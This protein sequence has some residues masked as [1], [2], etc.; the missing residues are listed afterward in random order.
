MGNGASANNA[1][2]DPE[3]A[4]ETTTSSKHHRQSSGDD[5]RR[6][7]LSV[8]GSIASTGLDAAELAKSDVERILKV[9]PVLQK[10]AVADN[11]EAMN[12]QDPTGN[13]RMPTTST[14]KYISTL[15]VKLMDGD[16]D[17]RVSQ[18]DLERFFEENGYERR[19]GTD[20]Y[21]VSDDSSACDVDHVCPLCV[22]VCVC[23]L[24]L[25]HI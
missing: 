24:S 14:L 7:T 11:T 17:G 2:T 1:A 15:T 9:L 23:V 21:R 16:G 25:I 20:F 18:V 22:C 4:D 6:G 8:G 19:V 10:S 3:T 12:Q 5:K 13:W